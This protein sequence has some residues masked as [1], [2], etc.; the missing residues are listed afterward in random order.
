M[1]GFTLL[2]EALALQLCANMPVLKV[3][4][5][6]GVNDDK[7]WLMIRRYVTEAVDRMSLE[8]LQQIGLDETSVAKGHDYITLFVDLIKKKIIYITTGKDSNTVKDFVLFLTLHGGSADQITD[9]SADMSPA[10]SKGVAD[11]L[12]RAELTY[13]KFH[14]VKLINEA[15]DKVR[16]G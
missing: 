4:E 5:V 2:F 8:E 16:R 14:I 1:N 10:F 3:S 13:D 12:P 15:V 7:L 6:V 9:V 11:N